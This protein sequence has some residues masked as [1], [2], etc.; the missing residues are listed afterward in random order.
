MSTKKKKCTG[1][2]NPM[3]NVPPRPAPL[4]RTCDYYAPDDGECH[5]YA[6]QPLA[7][8]VGTGWTAWTWPEVEAT[9]FCGEWRL[10]R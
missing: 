7:G 2:A 8:G 10:K 3:C 9:S 1:C 4:C 5:R 6:P